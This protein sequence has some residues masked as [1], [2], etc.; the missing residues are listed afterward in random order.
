MRR[1][2]WIY[3]MI[4]LVAC[5]A[6]EPQTQ[7]DLPLQTLSGE[8]SNLSDYAGQVVIVNFWATWCAPCRVEMPELDA[9]YR[10]HQEEGVVVLAV[11]AGESVKRVQAYIDQEGYRFP[12]LLDADEAVADYF[13]G[14]RGMP[15]TFVLNRHGEIAYQHIGPLDQAILS[16]Q[17][18]PLL[19]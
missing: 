4:L 12:V 8:Q 9:F 18:F 5:S 1:L 6:S 3:M 17:V 11:N 16:E 19:P 2:G 13:G 10:A 15:T 7:R 14:V